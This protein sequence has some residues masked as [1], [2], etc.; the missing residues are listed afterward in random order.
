[1][2]ILQG[3]I[4]GLPWSA[5]YEG[6]VKNKVDQ[7]C[8]EVKVSWRPS[9]IYGETVKDLIIKS[10]VDLCSGSEGK[11]HSA[12]VVKS[13]RLILAFLTHHYSKMEEGEERV[14]LDAAESFYYCWGKQILAKAFDEEGNKEFLMYRK[15][16]LFPC[17]ERSPY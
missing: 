11:Q 6:E 13:F 4:V 5:R 7:I 9:W 2:L 16:P 12:E 17:N 1:M 8:P 3:I 14:A 10:Q 15:W